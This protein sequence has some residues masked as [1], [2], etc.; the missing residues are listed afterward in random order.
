MEQEKQ[1]QDVKETDQSEPERPNTK[2]CF[3][4]GLRRSSYEV[5]IME[6][7]QRAQRI[8]VCVCFNNLKKG[9]LR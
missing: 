5:S 6:M 3:C 1:D 7:E 9:G 4:G 2:A 8:R